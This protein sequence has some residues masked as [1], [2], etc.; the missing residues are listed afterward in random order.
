MLETPEERIKLLKAGINSK[1][2]ETLY[3][4]YNNFKVVRNP[5]L[6]DCKPKL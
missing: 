3:L 4:I 1:T 6:C 2:I 5:V